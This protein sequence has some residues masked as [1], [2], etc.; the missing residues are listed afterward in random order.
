MLSHD[1]PVLQDQASDAELVASIEE[2]LGIYDYIFLKHFHT[3]AKPL[4]NAIT[5]LMDEDCGG[6]RQLGPLSIDRRRPQSS[7]HRV[8][9]C[10]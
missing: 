7:S 1:V 2:V 9:R 4:L 3:T 6:F 8:R 10:P 5:K